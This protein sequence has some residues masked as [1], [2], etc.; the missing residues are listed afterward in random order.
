M[1]KYHFK[2]TLFVLTTSVMLISSFCHPERIDKLSVST[3]NL[4]FKADDGVLKKVEVETSAKSWDVTKDADW[5]R[6]G[7]SSKDFSVSVEKYTDTSTDRTGTITV[8]AGNAKPVTIAV[9]QHKAVK[10]TGPKVLPASLVFEA[11]ETGTKTVTVNTSVTSWDATSTAT[12]F[13]IQ[14]QDKTL[15]VTVN[16]LNRGADPREAEIIVTAGNAEEVKVKVK[17]DITRNILEVAPKFIF[18]A[19]GVTGAKSATVFTDAYNWEYA[20]DAGAAIWL[21][22]NKQGNKLE[23][24]PKGPNTGATERSAEITITAGNA[25][26]IIVIVR[27][28][29]TVYS[30][31]NPTSLTFEA[32]ETDAKII[33]VNTAAASWRFSCIANWLT[34]VKQNNTLSVAPTG[35]NT[36]SSDRT[37][38]I[39]ITVPGASSVSVT[40]IQKPGINGCY[41]PSGSYTATS[42]SLLGANGQASWTGI[43]TGYENYCSIS[44][45]LGNSNYTIRAKYFNCKIFLDE[46]SNIWEGT[47]AGLTGTY[48]ARLY[49]GIVYNGVSYLFDDNVIEI[50]YNS[51][52]RVLDFTNTVNVNFGDSIGTINNLPIYTGVFLFPKSGTGNIYRWDA[53][54]GIKLSISPS[55]PAPVSGRNCDDQL[56]AP[57]ATSKSVLSIDVSKLTP[58][59]KTVNAVN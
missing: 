54:S 27:Q 9:T 17:Q 31:V 14:K 20:E 39:I 5:I 3:D 58:I 43:I 30:V 38:S 46:S 2:L 26:P 16:A 56:P 50:R 18:F 59:K 49:Q 8:S 57:L 51:S 7:R 25:T 32:A 41:P 33:T 19:E 24:T 23:V 12:W 21:D 1:E 36:G 28:D 52:T 4:I 11:G 10:I 47:P 40:V 13:S 34:I 22:V 6:I 45:F 35:L 42:S 44:N 53:A 15:K 37:A 55:S 29:M 48:V